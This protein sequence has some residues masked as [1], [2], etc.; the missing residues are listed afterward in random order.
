MTGNRRADTGWWRRCGG[1]L[2]GT[3]GRWRDRAFGGA[4]TRGHRVGTARVWRSLVAPTDIAAVRLAR[5]AQ[6]SELRFE[7]T[8]D[9]GAIWQ[10]EFA[11]LV[12][13]VEAALRHPIQ[14]RKD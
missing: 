8:L 6:A 13:F 14:P 4:R 5:A 2:I 1:D 11:E 3:A 10:L 12:Q 7:P 9:P